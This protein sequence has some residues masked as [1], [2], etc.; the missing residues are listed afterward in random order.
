M[1]WIYIVMMAR[2]DRES[3]KRERL[4][5]NFRNRSMAAWR[6][7]FCDVCDRPARYHLANSSSAGCSIAPMDPIDILA[8]AKF[9]GRVKPYDPSSIYTDMCRSRRVDKSG[10]AEQC[11]DS[12]YDN[13]RFLKGDYTSVCTERETRRR[14]AK[15]EEVRSIWLLG[16]QT[17]AI[18]SR[19]IEMQKHI[20]KRRRYKDITDRFYFKKKSQFPLWRIFT[21]EIFT[22]VKQILLLCLDLD[23]HRGRRI[24]ELR[25]SW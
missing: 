2:R 6:Y 11:G 21:E 15:N 19:N 5:G 24:P 20:V 18:L 4:R 22:S 23:F 9:L 10:R 3:R 13:D 16:D 17:S 7:E 1:R 8:S 14:N 25:N 12:R